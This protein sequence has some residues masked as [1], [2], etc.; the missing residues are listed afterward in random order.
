[1]KGCHFHRVA[2]ALVLLRPI[3]PVLDWPAGLD[4]NVDP[5]RDDGA[6]VDDA[7]YL[8]LAPAPEGIAGSFEELL[9]IAPP[10]PASVLSRTSAVLPLPNTLP[11][12]FSADNLVS[13]VDG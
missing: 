5:V 11:V 6:D 12:V 13:N 1:M 9:N 10:I 2:N 8:F 4:L 3:A 7:G